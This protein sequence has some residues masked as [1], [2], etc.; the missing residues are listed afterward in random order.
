MSKSVGIVAESNPFHTGHRHQLDNLRSMGY[1]CIAV[2]MSGSRVQRGMPSMINKHS[3]REMAIKNGADVITE[4]PCPFSLRSAEGYA[5]RGMQ[6]LRAMGVEAVSFGSES[7]N[8]QLLK[9]IAEYLLTEKYS[10][11][12]K[13]YLSDRLP[14]ATAREKAIFDRFDINR[15]VVSASNDILA[16]EYIKACIAM[17]WQIKFVPVKRRGAAYNRTKIQDGYASASGIRKMVSEYRID[18]ALKY[19]PAESVKILEKH[20]DRGSYFLPDTAFEKTVLFALYGKTARDFAL[21]PDCNEELSHSFEKAVTSAY[22]MEGL[23]DRLPTKRYPR[24]RLNRIIMNM[25]TGVDRTFPQDIQYLRVL[26][27]SE[28]GEEFFR[29]M[30]KSCPLP[31]SHSAK[32]LGEKSEDCRRIAAAES[33]ACDIQSLL[34]KISQPPRLDYTNKIVKK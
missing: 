17:G 28:R 8:L 21:I 2:A 11:R 20:L 10:T 33:R 7:G 12:L 24:S 25:L 16:I 34:C 14:F 23:F 32:I 4:I 13:G 18:R 15:D 1:D 26:G 31:V 30:S 29:N 19:I 27:F 22:S 3:R 5:R 6:T 9:E